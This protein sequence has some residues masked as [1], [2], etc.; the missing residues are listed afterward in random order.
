M[1]IYPDESFEKGS[2]VRNGEQIET[3]VAYYHVPGFTRVR[4]FEKVAEFEFRDDCF[5]CSCGERVGSDPHCRNHGF[6]GRRP[7]Q[8]HGM[9]GYAD[10]DGRMP[11][12]VQEYLTDSGPPF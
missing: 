8:V 4:V 2:A 3:V 11:A 7:C 6:A 10:D 9:P 5:C 12:P 1:G